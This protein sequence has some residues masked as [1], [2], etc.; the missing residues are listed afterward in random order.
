[1]SRKLNYMTGFASEGN[2]VYGREHKE[3]CSRYENP[4]SYKEAVRYAKKESCIN[5]QMVVFK[6]VQV[7]PKKKRK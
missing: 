5:A 7:W 6:L 2:C 1:M 4:M 3:N